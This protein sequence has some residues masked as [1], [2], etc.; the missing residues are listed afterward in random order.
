VTVVDKPLFDAIFSRLVAAAE[1]D[2]DEAVRMHVQNALSVL[3]DN[4]DEQVLRKWCEEEI[5]TLRRKGL[6]HL[7]SRE[8]LPASLLQ[9]LKLDDDM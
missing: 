9:R 3:A 8:L 7:D 4:Y 5:Q 6:I 2:S 1:S